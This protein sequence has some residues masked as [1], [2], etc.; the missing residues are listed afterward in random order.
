MFLIKRARVAYGG[1]IHNASEYDTRLQLE[2]GRIVK[3][4]EVTWLTPLNP[5][6]TFALGLNYADHAAEL[7]FDAPSEPLIF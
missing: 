4:D 6:T 2:D 1:A 7:A 3:Q 5:R